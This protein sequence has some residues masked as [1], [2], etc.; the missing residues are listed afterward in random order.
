MF[1]LFVFFISVHILRYSILLIDKFVIHFKVYFNLIISGITYL[2][3]IYCFLIGWSRNIISSSKYIG[4]IL[5]TATPMLKT[6]FI[7]IKSY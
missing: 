6:V 7:K 1:I 3:D 4:T 5:Y 2:A